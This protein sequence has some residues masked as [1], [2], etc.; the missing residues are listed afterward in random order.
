[1]SSSDCPTD[2]E[3]FA[4]LCDVGA[5]HH[6]SSIEDHLDSCELC[7]ERMLKAGESS[8]RNFLPTDGRINTDETDVRHASRISVLPNLATSRF[9]TSDASSQMVGK[10]RVEREIARGGMGVVYQAFDPQLDRQVAI[11]LLSSDRL[12]DQQW[13][14]RFHREARLTSA[15]NHPN[16]V[17]VHEVDE[18]DGVP[19]LVTEFVDGTTLRHILQQ[20]SLTCDEAI[21]YATQIATGMAAAHAAEIIHRD[22]KPANIMIRPDGIIKILDFGLARPSNT[23]QASPDISLSLSGMLIG[24]VAYM[25]PEQARGNELDVSS[26]VFSFGTILYQMLTGIRPF[27]GETPSDV[28]AALLTRAPRPISEHCENIP[29][30]L[31]RLVQKCLNKEPEYRPTADRIVA[32]L[33]SLTVSL[34]PEAC[35]DPV[36]VNIFDS[37]V[38]SPR[39]SPSEVTRSIEINVPQFSKVGPIRYA[40]SG[41]VN[42]AWQEVGRGPIDIVFV[43]GWVSHLDWFWKNPSFA[44]FLQRLASFSRVILFDKR[45]TGLSDKVPVHELPSLETRMDDVRAV[46]ES[47]GSE[48][49]VLCGVSEGGPLCTLFAATYPHKT[50]AITMI[51]CYARRLWA[52]DYPWGPTAEQRE[53]FLQEIAGNWGGPL[54]IE[55]RAPSMAS[56]SAFREWWASYLRMGAS[57]GAAVALTKMNAQIDVR[58]IL[59]SIQV[60][61]LVIHR[62]G[63]RCLLVEEGRHMAELI[64]GA[65]FV[66]LPGDDHLPFVG[67]S[68]A[69]LDEIEEFLTGRRHAPAVDRVLATV[70]WIAVETGESES[71]RSHQ[72]LR[73]LQSMV[74]QQAQLFRGQ[75]LVHQDDA[76]V[77]T[78]DGPARAVRAAN[79][80]CSLVRRLKM[81]VRCGIDMGACDIGSNSVSGIVVTSAR[82]I[83]AKASI[84]SVLVSHSVRS[85]AAGSG[86][87]FI[88]DSIDVDAT[89]SIARPTFQ[90]VR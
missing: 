44:A 34:A 24:T 53:V 74:A 33:Q 73:R 36:D 29:I 48:R 46:M 64:P 63:D 1:M 81:D 31:Q 13:M 84:D 72:K 16:I 2:Q 32:Q 41:D 25:S 69:I 45:G 79:A 20:Q 60:P 40:Q 83:A 87:E 80:I 37:T 7:Q 5:D 42:I 61:T 51:G 3:I 52:E 89:D 10:Y 54:G 9:D 50:I 66:E 21:G 35:S 67:N 23:N 39:S 57:P 14:S 49:A 11:K 17:T 65:K 38:S 55:D 58:P 88:E 70:L 86:L 47:A 15:L 56:D 71:S 59:P 26:D 85:L 4:L 19:Y 76:L 30:N 82:K 62:T 18:F 27:Q 28:T 8:W 6:D 68:E 75:N 12:D 78:F 22:L 43:M 90:L 77:L